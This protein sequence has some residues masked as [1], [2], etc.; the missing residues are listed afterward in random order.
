MPPN[1]VGYPFGE[2]ASFGGWAWGKG[3]ISNGYDIY[4]NSISDPTGFA[5]FLTLFKVAGS[6]GR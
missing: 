3:L 5:S 6:F 4:L 1:L 2:L